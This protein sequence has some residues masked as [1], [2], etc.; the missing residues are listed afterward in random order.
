MQAANDYGIKAEYRTSWGDTLLSPDRKLHLVQCSGCD[1]KVWIAVAVE[2]L[3]CE[4][5]WKVIGI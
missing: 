4:E 3:Y 2:S 1:T 5:C